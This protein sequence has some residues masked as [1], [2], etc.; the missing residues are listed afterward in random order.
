MAFN[1][2]YLPPGKK[3]DNSGKFDIR[4]NSTLPLGNFNYYESFSIL[5]T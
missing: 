3:S 2:H 1:I 4:N 5:L